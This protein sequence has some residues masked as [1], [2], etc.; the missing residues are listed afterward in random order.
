MVSIYNIGLDLIESIV[1]FWYCNF[2]EQVGK[3]DSE[4]LQFD[5]LTTVQ[6]GIFDMSCLLV[7]I[8]RST[9]IVVLVPYKCFL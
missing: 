7:C 6:L 8:V 1:V 4:Y 5:Y 2:V 3:L 9:Y